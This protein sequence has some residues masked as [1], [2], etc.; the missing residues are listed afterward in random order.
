MKPVIAIPSY[1]RP[2][3]TTIKRLKNVPLDKYLFIRPEDYDSYKPIAEENGFRIIKLKKVTDIGNT[4]QKLVEYCN[5]KGF[6][7]VFMFDDD[8]SKVESIAQS[9][10]KITSAR[11]LYEPD[12]KPRFE[13]GALKTWFK[14]AKEHNFSLSSPTHR[15]Y[16]RNEHNWIQINKRPCIQ[17][18]L[19]HIPDI[20][21]VGNYK[22]LREVGNEDYYIQ[23]KLMN[24]GKLCGKIGLIEYDCPKIGQGSGGNNV[25]EYTDINERYKLYV[26][27]FLDNVCN[28]PEKITTKTTKTGQKSVQFVWKFYG[29]YRI[30]CEI[31][32]EE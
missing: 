27:T 24:A 16:E 25:D 31:P 7:W 21:S 13:L 22:S 11:I 5:S 8:I 30:E 2:Q 23:F 26:Q 14:I 4:R 12:E 20:I 19:L 18:V 10:D 6:E 3:A 17:C 9:G 28:D 29:G 15:A 1:K 32:K